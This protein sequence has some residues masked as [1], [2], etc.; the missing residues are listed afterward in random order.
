MGGHIWDIGELFYTFVSNQLYFFNFSHFAGLQA[1]S[2]KKHSAYVIHVWQT[3]EDVPLRLDN[4]N[5]QIL[6]FSVT[7]TLTLTHMHLPSAGDLFASSS[8]LNS[9]KRRVIVGIAF[10]FVI[11]LAKSRNKLW[12]NF[13]HW[14]VWE[15][16]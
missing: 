11:F 2:R 14:K 15:N 4:W 1:F 6:S 13:F 10:Y 7:R 8:D 5:D 3:L 16:K 9:Y 12:S